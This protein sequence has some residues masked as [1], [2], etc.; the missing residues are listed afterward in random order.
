[1]HF[2]TVSRALRGVGEVAPATRLRVQ[3]A[4]A[5]LGYVRDPA[6]LAL[7][8]RK[9][10]GA[11]GVRR[12]RI[13]LLFNR[14]P[15]NGFA[16]YH[17][18]RAMERSVSA[19]AIELGYD[20]EVLFVDRDEYRGRLLHRYLQSRSIRGL[21]FA[22][23]EPGRPTVEL[24][25]DEYCAVKFDSHRVLPEFTLVSVDQFHY[26][27]LAF[28]RMREL[29]YRRIGLA[30][31][32]RDEVVLDGPHT[33]ALLLEQAGIADEDR[34]APFLI[35]SG[36]GLRAVGRAI[37][38]WVRGER[39][40]AVIS[41][42]TQVWWLVRPYKTDGGRPVAS[43]ALCMVRRVPHVAGIDGNI[44]LVGTHAADLLA[45]LLQA[46]RS[47]VPLAATRTY[48]RGTWRDGATAPPV[49]PR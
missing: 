33:A 41:N 12:Q 31:A 17:H 46:G 5:R 40:D 36:I 42:L 3:A 47:G 23:F 19:R 28:R 25:W 1:M 30:V 39:I 6:F 48:I 29:G 10:G 14:A 22:A 21:V 26:T 44:G 20:C 11:G 15:E 45:G 34:V 32:R 27:R 7:C 13:A 2:A 49:R 4:A 35:E 43:A 18:Y 9:P 38:E 37:G 8:G 16:G 24:P